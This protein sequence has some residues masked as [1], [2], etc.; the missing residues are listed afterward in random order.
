MFLP[1]FWVFQKLGAIQKNDDKTVWE[2]FF[3]TMLLKFVKNELDSASFRS[4]INSIRF[5]HVPNEIWLKMEETYCCLKNLKLSDFDETQEQ[6]GANLVNVYAPTPSNT[7]I[8]PTI[9][10]ILIYFWDLAL[11]GLT[12]FMSWSP[13]SYVPQMHVFD[14]F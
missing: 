2:V 12:G 14:E 6:L 7:Y 9:C 8:T 13:K 5:F 4:S 11:Y 3:L 1:G 10:L